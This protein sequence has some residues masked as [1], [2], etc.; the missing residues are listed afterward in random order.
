MGG[1][2]VALPQGTQ[3]RLAADVPE[4]EVDAGGGEWDQGDILAD[5]GDGG[6]GFGREGSVGEV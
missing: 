1:G 2:V 4:L 3:G 6:A 5:G